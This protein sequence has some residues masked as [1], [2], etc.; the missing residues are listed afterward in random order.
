MQGKCLIF[1]LAL[2][3]VHS[4]A[5]ADYDIIVS[6][7]ESL[8]QAENAL[9]QIQTFQ[10]NADIYQIQLPDKG[11]WY[12]VYIG[13]FS[14]RKE[15]ADQVRSI[16]AKGL[17]KDIFIADSSLRPAK[18]AAKSTIQELKTEKSST[19]SKAAEPVRSE[20]DTRNEDEPRIAIASITESSGSPPPY[21]ISQP[22]KQPASESTESKEPDIRQTQTAPK[23]TG[24]PS[25]TPV[26]RNV[27]S[28]TDSS[29]G[30]T[31]KLYPGDVIHISIPGQKEMTSDYDIDPEGNIYLLSG[32]INVKGLTL[33]DVEQAIQK[34]AKAYVGKEGNVRADLVESKR[35]ILIQGGVRYPGW[36]RVAAVSTIRDMIAS[37]GGLLPGVK[38]ADITLQRRDGTA[39]ESV[40]FEEKFQLEPNE[41]LVV[42][43]PKD[44]I[45]K[46]DSGD[47][48]FVSVPQEQIQGTT[49]ARV[50]PEQKVKQNQIEVDRNGYIYIPE[51]GHIFVNNMSTEQITGEISERLP[52]YLAKSG[53]VQVSI[54]E[55][56][57]WV[58]LLG[59]VTHPGWYNISEL[60]NVQTALSAAGGAI[61]G[62]IMTDIAII[63]K[64]GTE[65]RR[66]K[67]N[68]YQFS[69]TGDARLLPPIHEGDA[70]F[71]PISSSFGGIK[72]TLSQWDPPQEKL[73][74]DTK[75]KVRIFGAVNNSGVYEA[76]E[77]INLLDLLLMAGGNRDDADLTRVL[78]IR[79]GKATTYDIKTLIDGKSTEKIPEVRAGD[80]VYVNYVAKEAYK[81]QDPTKQVR[82]VG[83][84][85]R[86]GLFDPIDNMDLLDALALAG[87]TRDDAELSNVQILR[88]T[89]TVQEKYD[90]KALLK[91]Y[92]EPGALP[93]P[94]IFPKDT[95]YV[96]FVAKDAYKREDTRT[97]VRIFG[98]VNKPG[99]YSPI[100]NMDLLEILTLAYGIRD[101]ANLGNIQIIRG[102]TNEAEVYDLNDIFLNLRKGNAVSIP[103]VRAKDTVF[104]GYVEKADYQ[105]NKAFYTAGKV[106]HEGEFSIPESGLTPIQAIALSGGLDEWADP[107]HIVIIRM[108]K[109]IQQNIPY[110]YYRGLAGKYPE[111]NLRIMEND[112]IYVP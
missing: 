60:D 49:E 65:T 46:V 88:G 103:K 95:V 8:G 55:K 83:A 97:M 98:A 64:V 41:V 11:L 36:Y 54:I 47:L 92:G 66:F 51:Y 74:Q 39:R 102:D 111:I 61:D 2:L 13:P 12:R 68:L 27:S 70:I 19:P 42:P 105:K 101:D 33:A 28:V 76:K 3:F 107:E 16:K 78:I 25:E 93:M 18:S 82:V 67:V 7:H 62:A 58:Q 79:D 59:H 96:A 52:K 69:I 80:T 20:T 90:F 37:A 40:K 57:H 108:V 17:G 94:K 86:P 35:Y 43:T 104:V 73:E 85:Y 15:A 4:A 30:L 87:G 99:L 72:R 44:F 34:S 91:D 14:T 109:G 9:K 106:R 110:N 38:E 50:T 77:D 84:V 71:V 63:R 112:T 26:L 45:Q 48:L 5:F 32:P 56:R 89:G 1:L 31:E 22:A 81:K 29:K 24:T 75:Q 10:R 23:D 100:E 21:A 53:R 6:S